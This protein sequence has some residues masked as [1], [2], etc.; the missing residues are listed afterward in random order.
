LVRQGLRLSELEQ[1][2]GQLEASVIS[3]YSSYS[4]PQQGRS[5]D[6]IEWLHPALVDIA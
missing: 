2:T 4:P 5:L 3:S 6:E 1:I